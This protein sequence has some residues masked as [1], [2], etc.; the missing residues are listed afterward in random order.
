MRLSEPAAVADPLSR[1]GWAGM[2][3]SARVAL[4][5]LWL[6]GAILLGVMTMAVLGTWWLVCVVA[7]LVL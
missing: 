5:V 7:G 2:D 6:C 4:V 1:R 3:A